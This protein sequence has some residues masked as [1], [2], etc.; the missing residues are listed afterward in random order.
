MEGDQE[1]IQIFAK[2]SAKILLAD[3]EYF[4]RW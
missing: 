1:K 3:V 2:K 4:G